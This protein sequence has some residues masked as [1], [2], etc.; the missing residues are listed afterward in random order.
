MFNRQ[1]LWGDRFNLLELFS[2]KVGICCNCQNPL[3]H[4]FEDFKNHSQCLKPLINNNCSICLENIKWSQPLSCGHCFHIECLTH[5]YLE[6][7]P[8]CRAPVE[9]IGILKLQPPKEYLPVDIDPVVPISLTELSETIAGALVEGVRVSSNINIYIN[10]RN[11]NAQSCILNIGCLILSIPE[12]QLT[13]NG[14]LM[15]RHIIGQHNITDFQEFIS[16]LTFIYNKCNS[17]NQRLLIN[18]LR[19]I[20][21]EFINIEIQTVPLRL[22]SKFKLSKT[23]NEDIKLVNG[24][25]AFDTRVVNDINM[26]KLP[27]SN[28][29]R[30]K[31]IVGQYFVDPNTATFNES[32]KYI[33]TIIGNDLYAIYTLPLDDYSLSNLLIIILSSL[34]NHIIKYFTNESM[35]NIFN[36]HK[37]IMTLE[38]QTCAFIFQHADLLLNGQ[39]INLANMAHEFI[40]NFKMKAFNALLN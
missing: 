7:C 13:F 14:F 1:L 20:M 3:I 4:D 29:I 8:I 23:N 9:E 25:M 16:L 33:E 26:I 39:S 6:N 21:S 5:S 27:I 15:D 12:L 24:D 38:S 18:K 32:L 19:Q 28:I 17:I 2:Q 30:Y 11:S 31:Q 10:P 37:D 40:T 35:I 36:K 22:N 34:F